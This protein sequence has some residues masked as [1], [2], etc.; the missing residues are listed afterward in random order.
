[1]AAMQGK[2]MPQSLRHHGCTVV[3]QWKLIVIALS[4]PC[5]ET[6]IVLLSSFVK[7]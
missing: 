5:S 1:M 6:S 4:L 3:K 7:S 2:T